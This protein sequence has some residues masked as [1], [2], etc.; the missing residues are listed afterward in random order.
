MKAKRVILVVLGL[1]A[2]FVT[3]M[4]ACRQSRTVTESGLP[5]GWKF[6]LAEGDAAAGRAAFM[7]LRCYMCHNVSLPGDDFPESKPG[8][9]RNLRVIF[10]DLPKEY[11]AQCLMNVHTIV[12]DPC[13][14]T[15]AAASTTGPTQHQLTVK[16]LTDLV[17]FLR[18]QPE[19]K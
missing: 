10:A 9:G 6:T 1:L 13:F 8:V 12:P 2:V 7:E 14:D 11:A 4:I 3:V 18:K 5:A 15:Q 17:A 19:Q 16:E